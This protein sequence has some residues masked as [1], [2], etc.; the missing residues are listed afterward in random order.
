[1]ICHAR[2]TTLATFLWAITLHNNQIHPTSFVMSEGR[3]GLVK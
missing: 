2:S 3:L 1:M